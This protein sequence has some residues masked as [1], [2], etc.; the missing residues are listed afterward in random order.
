MISPCEVI[1]ANI[2]TRNVSK[3]DVTVILETFIE[4]IKRTIKN[5][6][7]V[8]LVGFGTFGLKTRAPRKGR[9]PRTGEEIQ[10]KGCHV[11]FFRPGTAFKEE[12]N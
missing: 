1:A 3:Q 4:T 9:N 11:P 2:A 10:I 8:T 12:V 7:T 5:G 6:E